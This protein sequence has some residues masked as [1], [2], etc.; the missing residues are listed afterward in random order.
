MK[1]EFMVWTRKQMASRLRGLLSAAR[2]LRGALLAAPDASACDGDTPGL[3]QI[4][5][6][7]SAMTIRCSPKRLGAVMRL[8]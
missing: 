3:A 5:I 4:T 1:A 6:S 7:D 8:A 2:R